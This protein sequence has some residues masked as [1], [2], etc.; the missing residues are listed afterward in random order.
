ML[1]QLNLK[2]ENRVQKPI[3]K[4]NTQSKKKQPGK[5]EITISDVRELEIRKKKAEIKRTESATKLNE[6]RIEKQEGKLIPFI[7]A[8]FLLSY[9]VEKKIV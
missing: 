8:E 2:P 9:I 1:L 3:P 6:L 4:G 7:E 5:N